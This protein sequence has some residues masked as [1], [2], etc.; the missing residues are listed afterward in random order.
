[1]SARP[2]S[3]R[4]GSPRPGSPR[5]GSPRHAPAW[6]LRTAAD[7]PRTADL[8]IV[9]GGIVGCATAFFAT[10]AGLDVVVLEARPRLATLTTPASTGAFRLQFDN[11]EEIAL[12]REGIASFEGFAERT[13][14][15][16]YD[17]GLS[18][19]GY[20]F[21]ALTEDTL[22]RQERMVEVQ[23]AAGVENIEL[24]SGD[25]ARYR[26]PYLSPSVLQA[27]YR[28]GDGFLDPVRLAYGYAFAAS[29]GR[30][31]ER[32]PGSGTATFCLGERAESVTL[33]GGRAVG[34]AT[35]HAAVS[36]QHIVLATGPFLARTAALAGL[37]LD[38]RPTRRQKLVMP[39]VPE[40]PP[41]AP[42][43][44][45]E[46]TAAHWRPWNGG[47]YLLCTETETPPTDPAWNV[48]TSADFAFRLLDPEAPTG[49]ARVSPFWRHAWERGASWLL[50]AGQYEYTPDHR[51]YVGATSV[52][53]LWLNGGYSGH[54]IMASPGGSRLLADLL[55]G[56][57]SAPDDGIRADGPDGNP[58]RPDRPMPEREF[59][60]L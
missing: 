4:P 22:G 26:F 28:A 2:V 38:L 51:P 58:F 16:G 7:P 34:V 14:L 33:V 56:V 46:E 24:L 55:T 12:V 21:C 9:G 53:G 18:R 40:V 32:P 10:R 23:R 37:R 20:L 15:D 49:V 19:N 39:V 17:L 57:V 25:E 30:G 5:P 36:A 43:T 3:P 60:I 54:G 1:V 52:P 48:P 31:V 35:A 42:M 44:I 59:D 6:R 29:G 45:H 11:A 27:R 13:G 47:A 41:D 50:M 8:V